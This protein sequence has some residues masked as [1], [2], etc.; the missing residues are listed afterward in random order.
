MK[1]IVSRI[2][3]YATLVAFAALAAPAQARP[4]IEGVTAIVVSPAAGGLSTRADEP[5]GVKMLMGEINTERQKLWK[6]FRGSLST[7]A[8]RFAFYDQDRRIARLVLD[9][10]SL[11][12]LAAASD[13]AGLVREVNRSDL[14]A[15]RRLAARVKSPSACAK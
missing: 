13:S 10:S 9:G 2:A 15:V 7:C 5:E 3:P 4:E 12:E 6:P 14:P 11:I 1:Y 8:V